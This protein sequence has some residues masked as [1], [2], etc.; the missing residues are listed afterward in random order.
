MEHESLEYKIVMEDGQNTEVRPARW[1]RHRSSA[2]LAAVTKHPNR[3]LALRQGA[4]VIKQHDGEPKPEPPR[5]PNLKSLSACLIGG[6]AQV[7]HVEA[8]DERAAIEAAVALSTAPACGGGRPMAIATDM[9]GT[10]RLRAVFSTSF[11]AFSR[12]AVVFIITAAIAHTPFYLWYVVF[13]PNS[14]VFRWPS[15]GVLLGV[16]VIDVVDLL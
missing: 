5:D 3:N 2:Y 10:F 12:H 9:Q 7:G 8:A 14:P 15:W 11:K 1:P 6:Q 16:R 13:N 4:R